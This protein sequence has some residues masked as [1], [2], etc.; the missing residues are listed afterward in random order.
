MESFDA[1]LTRDRGQLHFYS[2]EGDIK[3]AYV[4]KLHNKT[5]IQQEYQLSLDNTEL[6]LSTAALKVRAE[7]RKTKT[8][9]IVCQTPC[10]LDQRS[11]IKF[12]IKS[13][14]GESKTIKSV[15]FSAADEY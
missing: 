7:N 4:L 3:N 1:H 8:L 13:G 11:D 6:K 9:F 5:A 15:F 12:D 2:S 10:N 14:S